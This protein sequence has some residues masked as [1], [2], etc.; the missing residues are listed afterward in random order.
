MDH[1]TRVWR[2][3]GQHLLRPLPAWLARLLLLLLLFLL[4]FLQLLLSL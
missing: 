3:S 4:L 2:E 1:A